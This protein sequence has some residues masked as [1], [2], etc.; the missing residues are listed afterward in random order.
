MRQ[1]PASK[2]FQK[3]TAALALK[4]ETGDRPLENASQYDLMLGK[5]AI[6]KR[7]LSEQQSMERRAE[8]KREILPEYAPWISGV[9]QGETGVQDDVLVT[10]M[11]W[12][13]DIG[14]LE[15]A[16]KI[17]EY[18]LK[19]K[20]SMPDQYLRTAAV[21][22]AEE[23]ADQCLKLRHAGKSFDISLVQKTMDITADQDMPDQVRAKLFKVLG[24]YIF[25]STNLVPEHFPDDKTRL[26]FT[27][28]ALTRAVDLHTQVGVKKDLEKATRDLNNITAT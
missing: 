16:L 12:F 6:D 4:V 7:R 3:V 10:V 21:V 13:I 8:I 22:I 11:V 28:K 1:T 2:H 17:A 20:L 14:D 24:L 26:E 23:V 19:Y 25:E 18:V 27:V 9:L 15:S 5:L